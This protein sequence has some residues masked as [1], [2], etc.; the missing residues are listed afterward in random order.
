MASAWVAISGTDPDPNNRR[1]TLQRILDWLAPE[2]PADVE[3]GIDAFATN[4]LTA[5]P[6]PF[7]PA[8]EISFAL[9]DDAAAEKVRMEVYDLAGRRVASLF[10]GTLPAGPH[11]MVWNGRNESGESAE[12]GIYFARLTTA[13]GVRSEKLVLLK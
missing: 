8:T 7:T 9:N 13:E 4:L 6:N 5:N 3:D 2:S 11:R 12:S 10:D 1:V